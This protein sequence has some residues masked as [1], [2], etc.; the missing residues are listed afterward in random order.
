MLQRHKQS[1][2][3]RFRPSAIPGSRR[4][5]T[6]LASS[7]KVGDTLNWSDT[8]RNV[9]GSGRMSAAVTTGPGRHKPRASKLDQRGVFQDGVL[10]GSR[11]VVTAWVLRELRPVSFSFKKASAKGV[12]SSVLEADNIR[13]GFVAQEVERTIPGIVQRDPRTDQRHLVYQDFIA[14]LTMAAQEHQ[15]SIESRRSE[16]ASLRRVVDTLTARV[17]LMSAEVAEFIANERDLLDESVRAISS[18]SWSA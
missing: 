1:S 13:F 16:V 12:K 11:A 15:H 18:E 2:Y 17:E 14:L 7:L 10:R 5:E 6:Q 8:E 3:D 4:R 9:R